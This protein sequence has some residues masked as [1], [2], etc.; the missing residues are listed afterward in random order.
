MATLQE[1]LEGARS[2]GTFV[3]QYEDGGRTFVSPSI[4]GPEEV[5]HDYISG[6]EMGMGGCADLR[7]EDILNNSH[8]PQDNWQPTDTVK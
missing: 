2:G 8:W 1:A 3:Y 6:H 5:T 4:Y 7:V